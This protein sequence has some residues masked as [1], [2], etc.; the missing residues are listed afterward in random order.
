MKNYFIHQI[1]YDEATRLS[2]DRGFIQ[3]D[4][5]LNERPDWSEYWPIRNFLR[6]NTLDEGSYYGFLSPKFK[7]KTTLESQ[8]VYDFCVNSSEDVISFSPYF[9][10]AAFALNIFEQATANHDGIHQPIED[11]FSYINKNIKVFEFVMPVSKTIF[12]NYFIAKPH[13]WYEWLY[14]TEYLYKQAED[15]LSILYAP[16]NS[17]I[18]HSGKM[19]PVKVFIIERIASYIIQSKSSFTVKSYN[20]LAL[21]FST[22]KV[23]AY[24][25]KLII[26][27]SLKEAYFNSKNSEYQKLFYKYRNSFFG[28]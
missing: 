15:Q 27:N 24:R 21:P 16:L 2:N 3:L 9:D 26:L 6:N 25:E 20:P 12:C 7:E 4:N 8:I 17:M 18:R 13:F 1:F 14:I 10:Q 11:I 22:S 28:P 23:S 19:Y 5:S